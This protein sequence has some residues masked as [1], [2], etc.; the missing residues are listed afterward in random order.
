MIKTIDPKDKQQK[1]EMSDEMLLAEALYL[2]ERD[3]EGEE[4]LD[5]QE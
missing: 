2:Y 1:V 5:S 4:D 3:L